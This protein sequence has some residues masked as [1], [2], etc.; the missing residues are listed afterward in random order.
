MPKHYSSYTYDD[1]KRLA[2]TN[3]VKTMKALETMANV[4]LAINE[5]GVA[6][7]HCVSPIDDVLA[8]LGT[9]TDAV[10]TADRKAFAIPRVQAAM[11]LGV[12]Y[13]TADDGTIMYVSK[14]GMDHIARDIHTPQTTVLFEMYDS[15]MDLVRKGLVC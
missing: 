9:T 5:R 4:K 14:S 3:P 8:L 7:I 15:A 12:H 10:L 2:R 1:L 11:Q 13:T 6:P